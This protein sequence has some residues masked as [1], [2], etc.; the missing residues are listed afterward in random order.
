MKLLQL[1][2][3]K[4][5]RLLI[6]VGFILFWWLFSTAVINRY[7]VVGIIEYLDPKAFVQGSDSINFWLSIVL[8]IGWSTT[9]V[10]ILFVTWFLFLKNKFDRLGINI[11]LIEFWFFL[12]AISYQQI[13]SY[14][15]NENLNL[16]LNITRS[17]IGNFDV[18]FLLFFIIPS[19]LVSG[20]IWVD[21]LRPRPRI[22]R[23]K[24]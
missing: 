19:L 20:F 4:Y 8:P 2:K 5:L 21:K 15:I 18:A 16:Y 9:F 23:S 10:P 6:N 17:T 1:P 14:L 7:L 3:N 22:T 13:T 11:F 12:V 24:D